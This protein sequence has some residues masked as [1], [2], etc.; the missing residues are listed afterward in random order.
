[1]MVLEI[2]LLLHGY[3]A[4]GPE[5]SSAF[6]ACSTFPAPVTD[7]EAEQYKFVKESRGVNKTKV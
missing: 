7:P 5:L 6:C 1:M 4:I 3:A 2:D